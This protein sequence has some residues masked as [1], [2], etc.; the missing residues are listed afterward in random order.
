MAKTNKRKT[1]MVSLMK[2]ALGDLGKAKKYFYISMVIILVSTVALAIAPT[3]TGHITEAL[4]DAATSGTFDMN[5][6]I[7]Q[8]IIL[9]VL[10]FLGYFTQGYINKFM[11]EVSQ[12]L[13]LELR[14]RA[15]DKLNRVSVSYL[16]T[17]SGGDI[18]SR[19]TNDV[20]NL[21]G[22]IEST[23]P[24]LFSQ[25]FLLIG[26]VFMMLITNWLLA[27]IYLIILPLSAFLTMMIS[28]KTRK[29]FSEQNESVG[30]LN[31]FVSDVYDNHLL[32]KAY[33][34]EKQ[35]EEEFEKLNKVFND[36]YVKSRFL[37]GFM[38]PLGTIAANLSFIALCIVGGVMLVNGTLTLGGFTAFLFYGNMIASPLASLGSSINLVQTGLTALDRVYEFLDV[39]EM[40]EETPV[41]IIEPETV[42]GSIKFDHVNFGYV[43][44]KTLM[45]DVNFEAEPG[46]TMAI[47]G[48]S[49]A[50]KTTLINL[51]MRFYELN[52]GRILIDGKDISEL[53][54]ENLREAFGMVL[55][56]SWI[57]DGTVAENIGY[58]NP[59]ATR[60]DII[61]AAELVHCDTFIEKL[62]DTYDTYLS[63]ENS[64]LSVGEKQ[65]L[66]IART[67]LADPSI[68]ILDEATSQVDTKTEL[69]ITQAMEKMM[70]DHTSF[71]I[72]HRLFTI[73]NADK[74]I[75]M[76]DG[77]IKEFG[78]HDELMAKK[79]LYYDMYKNASAAEM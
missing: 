45:Q 40:E 18:L 66:S 60:E 36:T 54:K 49:G 79:G 58:G 44:E 51:L 10:Y 8:C 28:G 7:Y 6:I 9:T 3:F 2:R 78:S 34:A 29:L 12:S 69:L 32:L 50:G 70:E 5:F 39:E 15:Q 61:R 62:P 16:D 27:L 75:F 47:V 41:E 55:Q 63:S 17:V 37:S 35:K 42:K 64:S 25:G 73:Q 1:S 48:P 33:G 14:N 59:N 68:L 20:I 52:G 11:V 43:P 65:L 30:A 53:S 46:T 19:L 13:V 38:I 31:G 71:I 67:V 22:T 26:I 74:I 76:K 72:A 4:K 21:S 77:D 57:F 56:D 24:T 23:I